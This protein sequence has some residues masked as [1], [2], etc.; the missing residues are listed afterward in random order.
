MFKRH[1]K[2][3][4]R[5]FKTN[6]RYLPSLSRFE[7]PAFVKSLTADSSDEEKVHIKKDAFSQVCYKLCSPRTAEP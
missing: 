5:I 1:K 3:N 6:L 2:K 4:P 7:V